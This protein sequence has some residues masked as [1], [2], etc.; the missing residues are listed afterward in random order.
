M[1]DR[2]HTDAGEP[3]RVGLGSAYDAC[4]HGRR[5]AGD[6]HPE[7]VVLLDERSAERDAR[8]AQIILSVDALARV[9]MHPHVLDQ[10]VERSGRPKAEGTAADRK[11]TH[12]GAGRPVGDE[13]GREFGARADHLDEP[14][15]HRPEAHG[16]AVHADVLDVAP[17]C[18]GHDGTGRSSVD[19]SLDGGP[20]LERAAVAVQPGVASIDVLAVRLDGDVAPLA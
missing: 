5:C 3:L 16:L 18:D 12:L 1:R 4:F 19:G 15:A 8:G 11:I 14:G 2:A 17:G 20:W 10:H 13:N 6:E 7:V 9:V